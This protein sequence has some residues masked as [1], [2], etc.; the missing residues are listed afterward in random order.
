MNLPQ[1]NIQ[2]LFWIYLGTERSYEGLIKAT[3][4]IDLII[5][6]IRGCQSQKQVKDCLVNGNTEGIK[7][8]NPESA[9]LAG[10][11]CFTERQAQA[12]LDLRLAKLIGLEI[13]ALQKEYEELVNQIADY[14]E[15]LNSKRAMTNAIKK[16]LRAIKKE[17]N[18]PRRTLIEDGKE[19]VF[20]ENAFIEQEVVFVQ[21]KFGYAKLQ[22]LPG[23]AQRSDPAVYQHII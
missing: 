15:I 16:D 23:A 5:E 22:Q 11:L 3:N 4:I 7:F 17:Y 9:L 2:P 14:E 1:E 19:A 6:I 8:K 20:D 13:M 10:N 21:D 12:I 18:R